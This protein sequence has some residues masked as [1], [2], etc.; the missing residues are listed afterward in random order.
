M[1]IFTGRVSDPVRIGSPFFKTLDPDPDMHF[2]QSLAL[3]PHFFPDRK[4]F[5]TLFSLKTLV[6]GEQIKP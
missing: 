2:W 6:S 4:F 3:D 1:K 5:Y